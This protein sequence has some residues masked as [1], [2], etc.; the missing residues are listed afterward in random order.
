[1]DLKYGLISVDDHVLEHPRVWE[2]RMSKTTWGDRI[3]HVVQSDGVEGWV[4][5]G[6]ALPLTGRGS[7][8]ALLPDRAAAPARWA[9]VP[10]PAYDPAERLKAMDADGVDVSVLYPTAAGMAGETFGQLEDPELEVACV[11]AYNDWLI[12]EWASVSPRFVPQCLVPLAPIEAGVT[13]IRR[14]VA[15]GHRGV[16]FPAT[17]M[18]ARELP[19]VNEAIYDPIWS[20]CE[21]LQVPV[22]F[23]SGSSA[24]L[25][26]PLYPEL[27]PALQAA[28]SVVNRPLAAISVFS[29][30][31]YSHILVRHPGLK[32][33]FAESSL[34]WG[35]YELEL[36]D[37]EF[38]RQRLQLEAGEIR[39][40]ELFRRQCYLTGCFDR[41]GIDLRAYIGLDNI[42][43][44]TN[45][46][47][48]S[49]TWPRSWDTIGTSFA[50]VPEHERQHV[51]VDN[52]D[53]LYG[54]SARV[55]EAVA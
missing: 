35:A 1:M 24:R 39:P 44:E 36:A 16:I 28:L 34:G 11:Q 12:E 40:S 9:D 8:G 33:V 18:L 37:H 2:E 45:F 41:A 32:V 5:D 29:N 22:C 4:V 19:H 6:R 31:L 51:L 7:V 15:R 38:E 52:A 53:R 55:P 26:F 10:S 13:E 46:P 49:S 3:P 20:V 43:W 50:G 17:P 48:A 25:E 30:V 21:E 42:L 23:H 14:A 47:Q 54:L 27:S